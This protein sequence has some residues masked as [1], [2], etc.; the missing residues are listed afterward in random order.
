MSM[1]R[2]I[3]VESLMQ[4]LHQIYDRGADYVDI[5]GV[6]NDGQDIIRLHFQDS[7]IDPEYLDEFEQFMEDV[8]AEPVKNTETST[9]MEMRKLTDDDLNQIVT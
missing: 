7:Y 6:I 1:I 8:D 4:I 9:K 5:E 3:H 2:R